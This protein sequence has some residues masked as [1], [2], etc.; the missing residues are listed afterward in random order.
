MANEAT[1]VIYGEGWEGMP[2]TILGRFSNNDADYIT[3]ASLSSIICVVYDEDGTVADTSIG[4]PSVT[5]A[6]SVFDTLQTGSAWTKDTTGYNFKH[7]VPSTCFPDGGRTYTIEYVF[8]ESD[9]TTF[10][11]KAELYINSLRQN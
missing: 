1:E 4:S 2:A 11:R 3:Q 5:I 6:D 7:T 9:G 8:T 10:A